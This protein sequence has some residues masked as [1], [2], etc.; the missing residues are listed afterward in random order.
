MGWE[1]RNR[2][3]TPGRDFIF[4]AFRPVLGPMGPGEGG[5]YFPSEIKRLGRKSH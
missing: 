1:A 2:G 3:S 5:G 4:K